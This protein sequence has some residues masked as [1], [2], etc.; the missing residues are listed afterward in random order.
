MD[1]R[2]ISTF[3]LKV[4]LRILTDKTAVFIDN[5]YLSKVLKYDFNEPK[6]D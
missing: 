2:Q 1:G 5:G 3:F 4:E 6:L